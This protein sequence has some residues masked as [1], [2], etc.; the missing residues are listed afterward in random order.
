M[1]FDLANLPPE[2][3]VRDRE[4]ILELVAEISKP[5]EV[6]ARYGLTAQQFAQKCKDK[7]FISAYKEA[8]R[9]AS[10]DL[11]VHERIKMKAAFL[12]EDQLLPLARAAGASGTSVSSRRD[13]AET[14]AKLADA[15]EPAKRQNAAVPAQQV[16]IQINLGEGAKPIQVEAKQL[17]PP[18]FVDE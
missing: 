12:L 15:W 7:M 4:L 6:L 3:D 1:S 14:L 17:P 18:E 16:S 13:V 10:S 9:Q 2:M 11:R 8:K 5:T